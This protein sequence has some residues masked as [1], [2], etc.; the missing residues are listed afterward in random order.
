ML[1]KSQKIFDLVLLIITEDKNFFLLLMDDIE[2]ELKVLVVFKRNLMWCQFK[3]VEQWMDE[4]VFVF[5]DYGQR[6]VV[7]I[8]NVRVFSRE[9]M[10]SLR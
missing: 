4:K 6:A 5:V 8:N 9:V 7:F 2:K 1:L 3:I 10:S